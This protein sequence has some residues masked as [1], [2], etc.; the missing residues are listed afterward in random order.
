VDLL[1]ILRS[2]GSDLR[3]DETP[4]P[5]HGV[6][7]GLCPS[8]PGPDPDKAGPVEVATLDA[9]AI[10]RLID[11]TILRPEATPAEVRRVCREARERAFAAVC[12]NPAWVRL[13][14]GELRGYPTVVASVAGFPLG[15]TVP[16]VKAAEAARA[17]EDG[18]RE[19][20]M[21]LSVGALKSG[22]HRAV[23]RDVAA[24]VA[25][26]RG[27]GALVKVIIETALLTDEEK[28]RACAIA[29]LAGAHFV[30][31]STGFGPAGATAADVALMRHVVGPGVGVKAAGGVRDW[32]AAR[33]MVA[34]GANRIGTSSGVKILEEARAGEPPPVGARG[35]G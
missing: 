1:A 32:K 20:D 4:C 31:T 21:V 2:L 15:A 25:A 11:H 16:E 5:C 9:K 22:D 28:V 6:A 3:P 8:R 26:C 33:A 7:G 23:E 29:K 12:V 13:S 34:A 19:V 18:A 35:L 27:G 24:V 10:A 14:A 17:V 30:K